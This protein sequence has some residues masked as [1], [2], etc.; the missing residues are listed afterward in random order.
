M[1]NLNPTCIYFKV[2]EHQGKTKFRDWQTLGHRWVVDCIEIAKQW[3]S[4]TNHHSFGRSI[5]ILISSGSTRISKNSSSAH[6]D[7]RKIER[8]FDSRTLPRRRSIN[9][10][11][12]KW[13]PDLPKLFIGRVMWHIQKHHGNYFWLRLFEI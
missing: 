5:D 2:K 7:H 1:R 3:S 13:C 11:A 10:L 9:Q 6:G 8:S 4:T 12:A